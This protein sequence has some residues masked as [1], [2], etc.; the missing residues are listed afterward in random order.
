[1]ATAWP[2]EPWAISIVASKS[3]PDVHL[4]EDRLLQ[5]QAQPRPFAG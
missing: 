1:M 3:V 4:V 2:M 5:T